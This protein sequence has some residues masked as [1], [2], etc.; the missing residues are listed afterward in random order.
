MRSR[1][2]RRAW[3]K[4]GRELRRGWSR[5]HRSP[6][7]DGPPFRRLRASHAVCVVGISFNGSSVLNLVLDGH[8]S[9]YGGGELHKLFLDT[10]VPRCSVCQYDCGM[11][12]P[13]RL[14]RVRKEG[15]YHDLASIFGAPVIVNSAKTIDY[16]EELH[17]LNADVPHTYVLLIKHPIRHLASYVNNKFIVN[18]GLVEAADRGALD[19]DHRRAMVRYVGKRAASMAEAYRRTEEGLA[20]V[21]GDGGH[22]VLR[23][24]DFVVDPEETLEPLLAE[25]GLEFEPSMVD[26][27]ALPHH[28]IGGNRG[29]HYQIRKDLSVQRFTSYRRG[30]YEENPGLAMDNKYLDTFDGDQIDAILELDA[31]RGL[32]STL[33]YD[34]EDFPRGR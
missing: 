34:P 9:I 29:P 33:G 30:Y 11:W 32:C 8:P 1:S 7:G 4:G 17:P 3:R 20:A 16:F 21:A 13:A 10:K 15:L 22:R 25:V 14:E 24:E 23:Y 26:Y 5:L 27:T 18:E 12:T 6:D 19:P 31:Y 2:L 28:P